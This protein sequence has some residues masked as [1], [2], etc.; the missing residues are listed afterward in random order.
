MVGSP[1]SSVRPLV[2]G[3]WS[4]GVPWRW[5][6]PKFLWRKERDKGRWDESEKN[7]HSNRKN[8][9]LRVSGGCVTAT[10]DSKSSSLTQ[11]GPFTRWRWDTNGFVSKN[12]GY[13]REKRI[14]ETHGSLH[15]SATLIGETRAAST[16]GQEHTQVS[17]VTVMVVLLTT[18]Q[19]LLAGCRQPYVDPNPWPQ[20]LHPVKGLVLLSKVPLPQEGSDSLPVESLSSETLLMKTVKT[21]VRTSLSCSKTSWTLIIK[22][23][24]ILLSFLDTTIKSMT[25]LCYTRNFTYPSSQRHQTKITPFLCIIC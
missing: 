8:G 17:V 21:D 6:V 12:N 11:V 18:V 20:N 25:S 23:I 14:N 15:P 10:G 19:D 9:F 13:G 3:R 7:F 5:T 22:W 1:R 16:S 4:R 2:S 24:S